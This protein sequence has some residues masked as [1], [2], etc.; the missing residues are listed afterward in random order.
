MVCVHVQL[1]MS[2]DV[3]NSYLQQS[4]FVTPSNLPGMDLMTLATSES[5]YKVSVPA[6]RDMIIKVQICI[7]TLLTAKGWFG[8]PS[9]RQSN[10]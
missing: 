5:K 9:T 4:F 10:K 2:A 7:A 8:T 6:E 1:V 3:P